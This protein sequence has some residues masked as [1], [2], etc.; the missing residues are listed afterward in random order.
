[1][2]YYKF[3]KIGYPTD[4][5]KRIQFLKT[6]EPSRQPGMEASESTF[7]ASQLL[8]LST[9]LSASEHCNITSYPSTNKNLLENPQQ[10]STTYSTPISCTSEHAQDWLPKATYSS[11]TCEAQNHFEFPK[12]SSGLGFDV[13]GHIPSSWTAELPQHH[14][15]SH[16]DMSTF[17]QMNQNFDNAQKASSGIIPSGYQGAF[18]DNTLPDDEGQHH[19]ILSLGQP[20]LNRYQDPCAPAST[21][22]GDAFPMSASAEMSNNVLSEDWARLSSTPPLSTNVEPL[23]DEGFAIM[24]YEYD[25]ST[26]A[27]N[28]NS[29][30]SASMFVDSTERSPHTRKVRNDNRYNRGSRNTPSP[31][32]N[33]NVR[34]WVNPKANPMLRSLF[35]RSMTPEKRDSA[36]ASGRNS[37]ATTLVEDTPR[38][39]HPLIEFK[40]LYRVPCHQSHEPQPLDTFYVPD[41]KA[42]ERFREITP[43]LECRYSSIHN[44]SWSARYLKPAVFKADLKLESKYDITAL[45]RVG[46]SALHY[47]AAGGAGYDHFDALIKAG[48]DPYQL[49]TAGQ[50]FLHCLRPHVRDM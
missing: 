13:K 11:P 48:V 18:T 46:N 12:V 9:P 16:T 28:G 21:R 6:L 1:M 43:C 31:V 4:P 39:S 19:D 20:E 44:L 38:H 35:I 33:N 7:L 40:G 26:A 41:A 50:L 8:P 10:M 15:S 42:M 3:R 17:S 5:N 23:L 49:N 34:N 37:P 47:A 29:D 27:L 36:Y 22:D 45:D 14:S 2:V 25:S 32:D 24:S 30:L